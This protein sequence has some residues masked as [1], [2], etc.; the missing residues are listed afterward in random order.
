[1]AAP[2]KFDRAPAATNK[3]PLPTS[4]RQHPIYLLEQMSKEVSSRRRGECPIFR[5]VKHLQRL[6]IHLAVVV[7]Y[8]NSQ[9]SAEDR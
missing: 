4:F 9:Q 5:I 3:T 6:C 2:V 8:N 7:A 1:M